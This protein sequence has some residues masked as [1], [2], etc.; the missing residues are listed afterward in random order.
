MSIKKI[1]MSICMWR[2]ERKEL[3]HEFGELQPWADAG[4]QNGAV[5]GA[6]C[7]METFLNVRLPRYICNCS[8]FEGRAEICFRAVFIL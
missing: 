5:Q 2:R 4:G 6:G 3:T 8:L 1:N 7:A